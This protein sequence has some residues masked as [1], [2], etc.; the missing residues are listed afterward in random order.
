M[1][2]IKTV[3]IKNLDGSVSQETYT[4]AVD[5]KN[6]DML[7]GKD[8]QDTIGN[9][10]IDKDGNICQQ[11]K[12]FK[13]TLSSLNEI[14]VNKQDIV[15]NLETNENTKVLSAKQ[16]NNLNKLKA[17]IYNTIADMKADNSLK[18]GMTVQ[19]LGYYEINDG[20]GAT[21]KITNIE[22]ET[23]YQE[24][25]ENGLYA[26]LI[27]ENETIYIKQFGAKGDGETDDSEAFQNALK[28]TGNNKKT[29]IF[30]KSTGYKLN[31]IFYL[32]SNTDINFNNQ[33][34]L[35]K[36]VE[37]LFYNYA[38][39][40]MA[41]YI[42]NITI[43][44]GYF[45]GTPDEQDRYCNTLKFGLLRVNNLLVENNTFYKCSNNRHTFDMGGC[46]N[47]IIQNN[48][49]HNIYNDSDNS[50]AE[51]IQVDNSS[52]SGLPYWNENSPLYNNGSCKNVKIIGNKFEQDDSSNNYM[53]AIGTHA[54]IADRPHED[55]YIANN[56]FDDPNYANIKMRYWKNVVIENNTF[57]I[58]STH[59]SVSNVPASIK[60]LGSSVTE[61]EETID[62]LNEN[63]I[64]SNNIFK[65]LDNAN[66]IQGI[67]LNGKQN[68]VIVKN[69]IYLGNYLVSGQETSANFL[70]ILTSK[71][72]Q[73]INNNIS[74]AKNA[75]YGENC[76]ETSI[77]NNYIKS[78]RTMVSFTNS[79][80]DYEKNYAFDNSGN[81]TTIQDSGHT[82]QL[83]NTD[84]VT[85][86]EG[87]TLN[88]TLGTIIC[89]QGSLVNINAILN[90][91]L[92]DATSSVKILTVS[93]KFRPK[94]LKVFPCY[95][96]SNN[97]QNLIYLCTAKID[98][99]GRLYI[100]N[101]SGTTITQIMLNAIY[102]LD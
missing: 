79:N 64:I 26:T 70:T 89:R 101:S 27:I 31:R 98:T 57:V 41:Q 1:D 21:Y 85:L 40:G 53:N 10:D 54:F 3:K 73:I 87:V 93:T 59:P 8:V 33:K 39:E 11:L 23:D 65:N 5:A 2:K 48:Y 71:G 6:V 7:N 22:S 35:I 81:I 95:G 47:V 32:Y 75:L 45:D 96:S 42:E 44:N 88:N 58:K 82:V 63:I 50:A 69:N 74:N 84:E 34:I 72:V 24:N 51:L 92:P 19:T 15:D 91:N 14:K 25:L 80:I 20:G 77:S 90:V 86:E 43:R 100:R 97:G 38:I 12:N 9:I 52:Y 78:C 67:A 66:T 62:Y 83:D 56:V 4:I 29:I 99:S 49:W 76:S 68:N 46:T 13:Q 28:C 16:G 17:T 37:V 30:N 55:I 18:T 60:A 102:C 36:R 94:V 61:N